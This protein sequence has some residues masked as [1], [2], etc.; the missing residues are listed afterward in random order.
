MGP[1]TVVTPGTNIQNPSLQNVIMNSTIPYTKLDTRNLASFQTISLLFS[2]EPSQP[3]ALDGYTNT[4]LYY[5]PHNY[6][7]IPSTWLMWQNQSPAFPAIPSNGNSATTF[8]PFGDDTASNAAMGNI[9]QGSAIGSTS[10]CAA[11]Y[12]TESGVTYNTTS[13][14]LYITVDETNVNIYFLK[15]SYVTVGGNVVPLYMAGTTLDIRVYVF[16]EPA[17][18]STY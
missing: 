1:M 9:L 14:F 13:G 12:T 11:V 18:T 6:T 3:A 8:Y 15:V 5:F 4:L 17:S 10:T 16:A 7:Y 2:H